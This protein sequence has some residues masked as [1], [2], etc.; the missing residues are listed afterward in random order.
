M[1]PGAGKSLLARALIGFLAEHRI[2]EPLDT[3]LIA[4]FLIPSM[5]IP[6]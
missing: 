5:P 4:L 1:L 6:L 3:A 2:E